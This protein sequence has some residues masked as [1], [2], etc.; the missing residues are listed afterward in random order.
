MRFASITAELPSP[1]SL[2]AAAA[3]SPTT[4]QMVHALMAQTNQPHH[5][6]SD[7]LTRNSKAVVCFMVVCQDK[8]V[9]DG[10]HYA[11]TLRAECADECFVRLHGIQL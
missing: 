9:S 10:D 7:G 8:A 5:G 3:N 2:V 1:S 6:M 11:A 4:P